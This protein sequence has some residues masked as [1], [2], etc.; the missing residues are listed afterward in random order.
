MTVYEHAVLRRQVTALVRYL[1]TSF[2]TANQ[3]LARGVEDPAQMRH[4]TLTEA[5]QVALRLIEKS[6]L[7]PL[8]DEDLE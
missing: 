2:P 3:W 8:K 7:A 1:T 4:Y 5:K 6:F